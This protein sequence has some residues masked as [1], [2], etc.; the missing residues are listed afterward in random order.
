M[1]DNLVAYAARLFL[2]STIRGDLTQKAGDEKRRLSA[3][4]RFCPKT[5]ETPKNVWYI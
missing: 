3:L 1:N 5:V 4:G 2:L